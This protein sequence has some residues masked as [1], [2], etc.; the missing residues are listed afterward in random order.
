MEFG[1]KQLAFQTGNV[2]T[3]GSHLELGQSCWLVT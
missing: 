1:F 2:T 3:Y